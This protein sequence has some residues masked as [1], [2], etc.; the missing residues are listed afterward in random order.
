MEY[1]GKQIWNE[2]PAVADIYRAEYAE[3]IQKYIKK[4]NTEC[5]NIR[6]N[7][8]P[9]EEFVKNQEYYREKYTIEGYD[10]PSKT[11]VEKVCALTDMYYSDSIFDSALKSYNKKEERNVPFIYSYCRNVKMVQ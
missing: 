10:E 7:S 2:D 11:A 5:K 4:M 9:P 8:M 1:L 3:G 6:R